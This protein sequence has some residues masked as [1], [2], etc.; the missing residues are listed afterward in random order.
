MED[1]GLSFVFLLSRSVLFIVLGLSSFS[2]AHARTW[3]GQCRLTSDLA[4]TSSSNQVMCIE[5]SCVTVQTRLLYF[6]TI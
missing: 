1:G 2:R 6:M 3:M 4:S 5:Y